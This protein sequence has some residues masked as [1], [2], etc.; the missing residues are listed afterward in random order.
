MDLAEFVP[1]SRISSF[2]FDHETATTLT[3]LLLRESPLFAQITSMA[4]TAL[5][6]KRVVGETS[7]A[8]S[9]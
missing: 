5:D 1:I 6:T 2:E 3:R 8:K 4:L 9:S 7:H